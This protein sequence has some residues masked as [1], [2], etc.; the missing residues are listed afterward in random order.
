MSEP[1]WLTV[2][3]VIAFHDEQLREFGG[4]EGVRDRKMLESALGRPRNKYT[5]GETDLAALAATCAYGL[6]RNHPLADGNKRASLLSVVTF[7]GLNDIKF[8]ANEAEEAIIFRDLAAS[9][10]DEDGL[11]RLI[12][13]NW[14]A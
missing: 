2:E 8:I 11:T 10:V 9:E 3:L 13:D 12:R 6:A 5:N 14:P 1:V 4:H 7:L